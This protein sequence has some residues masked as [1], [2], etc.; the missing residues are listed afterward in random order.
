MKEIRIMR[1]IG[2][3]DDN[4]IEEADVK[5]IRRKIKALSWRKYAAAAA[6][7]LLMIGIG[8]FALVRK[9]DISVDIPYDTDVAA[10]GVSSSST[11]DTPVENVNPYMDFD[12]LEGAE[13]AIGFDI[14]APESFDEFT[15]RSYCVLFGEILEI[16]YRDIS[17]ISGLSIRKSES[18]EDISGDFTDYEQVSE[19]IVCDR[20]ITI[21]GCE[22][23]YYLAV[24]Q[25]GDYSYSVSADNGISENELIE[26]LEKIK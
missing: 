25:D 9:N 15:E 5:E 7:G 16:Q 23:A 8:V 24:W 11:H 6:C 22:N 21:K 26:I 3:I 13:K 2:D 10:S 12:T 17:N 1:A 18:T 4:Y 20:A 14:E 19:I